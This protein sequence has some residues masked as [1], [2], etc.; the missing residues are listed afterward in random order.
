MKGAPQIP[1][2]FFDDALREANLRTQS[3]EPHNHATP[4]PRQRALSRFFSFLRHFKPHRETDPDTQSR[5]YSLSWT[6]NLVSGILR[7]RDGSDIQSQEVPY[8]AGKPRNYHATGKTAARPPNTHITQQT[9]TATQSTPPS[10]HQPPSIAT[11][12]TVSAAAGTPGK[13]GAPSHPHVTVAGWRA[14][15]VGWLCFVPVQNT[16]SQP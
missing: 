10:S 3:H 4:V 9:N 7:K 13:M 1:P 5:S 15:F 2:G 6:R 16:N 12:S 14:R 8:T 11:A